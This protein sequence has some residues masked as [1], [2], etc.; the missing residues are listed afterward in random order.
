[1][2]VLLKGRLK[3]RL[4]IYDISLDTD[5]IFLIDSLNTDMLI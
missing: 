2:T 1:M 4:D 5:D 3:Y